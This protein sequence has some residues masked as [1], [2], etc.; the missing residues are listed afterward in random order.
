MPLRFQRRMRI[1]AGISLNS[2][3]KSVS[4]SFGRR[5]VHVTVGPKG[6]RTTIGLPGTGLYYTIYRK[7]K[8]GVYL[9]LAIGG[10][11]LLAILFRH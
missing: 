10:I 8:P 5:G 9:I 11:I 6:K 3:K 1:M 4:A 2:N 7:G